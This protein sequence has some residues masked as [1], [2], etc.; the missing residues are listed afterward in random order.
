M[1]IYKKRIYY[2][3][4]QIITGL[5][6]D[7]GEYMTLDNLEYIGAY[8]KYSDGAIYTGGSYTSN[9]K[10]LLKYRLE[11][12]EITFLYDKIVQRKFPKKGLLTPQQ[13]ILTEDDYNIGSISRYLA[14]RINDYIG[15]S[16]IEISEKDYS[17]FR[18]KKSSTAFIYNLI[19]IKWKLTGPLNDVYDKDVRIESGVYDTNKRI[20]ESASQ[21][22]GFSCL[23]NVITDYLRYTTYDPNTSVQIKNMF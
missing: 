8:H 14:V 2:P 17:K 21:R 20:I 22:T 16:I 18:I 4:S 12:P 13:P 5:T 19:E 6:T 7:G 9:S 1:S 11:E 3:E 23:K 10:P 15:D